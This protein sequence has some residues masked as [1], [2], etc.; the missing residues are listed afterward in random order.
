MSKVKNSCV[1]RPWGFVKLFKEHNLFT[2]VEIHYC[3]LCEVKVDSDCQYT[4]EQ[5]MKTV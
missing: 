1:I 5:H 2:D 4:V 3:K